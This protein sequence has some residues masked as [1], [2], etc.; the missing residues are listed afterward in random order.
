[1]VAVSV[2]A[3]QAVLASRRRL[4]STWK[5][6]FIQTIMPYWYGNIWRTT[7]VKSTKR[8]HEN[9]KVTSSHFSIVP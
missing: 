3:P 8:D 4:S 5:V 2:F 1:M 6:F 7:C 9:G